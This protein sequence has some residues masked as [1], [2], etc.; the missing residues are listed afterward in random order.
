MARAGLHKHRCPACRAIWRHPNDCGGDSRPAL[1]RCHT[2][3]RCGYHRR[4]GP[5]STYVW[6]EG[7][8]PA[9]FEYRGPH[10]RRTAASPRAR[11][12][13]LRPRA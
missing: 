4:Y 7:S 5:R 12:R 1:A 8:R 2:C 10:G 13:S 3:P 11:R 6:Y 9:D